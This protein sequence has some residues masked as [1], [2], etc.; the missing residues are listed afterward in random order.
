MVFEGP[1]ERIRVDLPTWRGPKRRTLFEVS[2][3]LEVRVLANMQAIF[4]ENAPKSSWIL[5]GLEAEETIRFKELAIFEF[6]KA[7]L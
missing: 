6:S 1:S 7:P 4:N 3:I 5:W 2:W